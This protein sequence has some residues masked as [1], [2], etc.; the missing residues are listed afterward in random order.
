ML[1]YFVGGRNRSID[2]IFISHNR[3]RFPK[4]NCLDSLYKVHAS[5]K[6]SM[7]T[8][9]NGMLPFLSIQQL[10]RSPHVSQGQKSTWNPLIQD[11]FCAIIVMLTIDAKM[12]NR[13]LCPH[14]SDNCDHD[15]L[16]PFLA[17]HHTFPPLAIFASAPHCYRFK[18]FYKCATFLLFL[19]ILTSASYFY[20]Y[21]QFLWV[22]HIF[23]M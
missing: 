12:A 17:T 15:R 21:W 7:E 16:K 2:L 13:E 4:P 14:L 3:F 8:K 5:V 9:C 6:F 22:S 20:Q 23:S 11:Y 19:A 1:L 18:P 10:N